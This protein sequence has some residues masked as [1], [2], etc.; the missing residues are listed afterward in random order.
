MTPSVKAVAWDIDGTLIDSEP[1]HDDILMS[2]CAACGVD[3]S[4]LPSDQFLGV[5]VNDVWLSLEGRLAGRIKRDEWMRLLIDSYVRRSVELAGF[6]D[7]IPV[8]QALSA[9]EVRQVCVS[10]SG[11]EIVNANLAAIGVTDLIDF[12]I[13]LDDVTRG[14]PDAEPYT[15][16]ARRLGLSPS[17]M[18]AIEDS[19]TGAQAAHAAGMRV[20]GI[21]SSSIPFAE[22]TVST[23]EALLPYLI[24]SRNAQI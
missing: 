21:G 22:A 8:M 15:Q 6:P 16:A 19:P 20:L 11:R 5:H 10:N 7:V 23:R 12:S 14:K 2:T 1:V 3:L 13:S 4:D 18:V 17:Q 9:R 24:T